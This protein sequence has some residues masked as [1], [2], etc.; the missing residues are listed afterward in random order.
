LKD[1]Q[2]LKTVGFSSNTDEKPTVLTAKQAHDSTNNKKKL[3]RAKMDSV[4]RADV[5]VNLC[6]TFSPDPKS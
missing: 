2:K 1:F 5:E 6:Y 3:F 4:C